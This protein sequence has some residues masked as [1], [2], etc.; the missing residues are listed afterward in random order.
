MAKSS[1]LSLGGGKMVHF[2]QDGPKDTGDHHLGNSISVPDRKRLF[3]VINEGNA[4]LAAIIGIDR[5]WSVHHTDSIPDGAAASGSHLAFEP[6]RN[7][8]RNPGRNQFPISWGKG[9]LPLQARKEVHP[10]GPLGHVLREGC[11]SLSFQS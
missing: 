6:F 10:G 5:P 8:H 7:C 9:D 4:N 2:F 3:S 11:R 1:L